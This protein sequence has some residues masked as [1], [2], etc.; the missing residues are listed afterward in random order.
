MTTS[1]ASPKKAER[2]AFFA[3]KNRRRKEA[4]KKGRATVIA[5]REM[6]R[7]LSARAW[8]NG[9]KNKTKGED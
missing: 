3:E 5:N 6:G 4:R 1:K 9:G 8:L 7:L 2:Q